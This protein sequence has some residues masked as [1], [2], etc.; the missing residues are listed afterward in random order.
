MGQ[1]LSIKREHLRVPDAYAHRTDLCPPLGCRLWRCFRGWAESWV[2]VSRA[3]SAMSFRSPRRR[4]C[5]CTSPGYLLY[6]ESPGR[7]VALSPGSWS[8]L[9][10]STSTTRYRTAGPVPASSRSNRRYPDSPRLLAQSMHS[11][12]SLHAK[13]TSRVCDDSRQVNQRRA[14]VFWDIDRGLTEH[15]RSPRC[16][17]AGQPD[18]PGDRDGVLACSRSRAAYLG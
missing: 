9:D 15:W 8:K 6:S 7:R 3:K 4:A 12:T 18:F 13:T 2:S 5:S 16:K 10:F 17:G 1:A 14:W 11:Y